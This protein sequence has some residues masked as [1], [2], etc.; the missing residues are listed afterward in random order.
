MDGW[1]RLHKSGVFTSTARPIGFDLSDEQKTAK[2]RNGVGLTGKLET[3]K[4][5]HDLVGVSQEREIS[6]VI[7]F[8]P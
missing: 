3:A 6:H 1:N 5:D 2:Y 4:T 7:N 8:T